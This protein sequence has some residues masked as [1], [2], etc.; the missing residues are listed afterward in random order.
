[1]RFSK[2]TNSLQNNIGQSCKK[3]TEKDLNFILKIIRE[4]NDLVNLNE[5]KVCDSSSFR[6]TVISTLTHII[7]YCFYFR[8]TEIFTEL[9]V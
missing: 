6:R 8:Y 2:C 7:L 5:C 9:F 1:M 4:N 3:S